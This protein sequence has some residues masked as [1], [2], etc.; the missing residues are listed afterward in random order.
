MVWKTW[1][2]GALNQGVTSLYGV[3]G[4]PPTR[5]LVHWGS[6]ATT[7]DYP[8]VALYELAAVGYAY[9]IA[10]PS[11]ENTRWLNVAVKAPGVFAEL[12]LTWLLYLAARRRYGVMAARW[13]STAYWSNPATILNGAVLGYI[14]P[15]MALP[16]VASVVAAVSGTP[17]LA[18][19]L[20]A[21]ACLTKAQAVFLFPVVVLAA[22]NGSPSGSASAVVRTLA[23]SAGAVAA[24]LSPYLVVGAGRN[25]V[26]GVASLLRHDMLSAYAA[27]IW[28]VVTYFLRASY[29][30]ADMG[31]WAAWTMPMRILG[32]STIVK[33]GYPDPRPFATT[34]L[35]AAAC[36]ALW[37]GRHARDLA[38]ACALGA[39][40]VHA[41]FVLG[42]AVHEN[43]LY[44]AVPLL[45]FAGCVRPR[46]RRVHFAVSAVIALNLFLFFGFG[47]ALP[48]PPRTFT[49]IDATVLLALANCLL[50]TWHARNFS[51]ECRAALDTRTHYRL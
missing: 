50:F 39:F 22:W 13:A 6:R 17:V 31:V 7:V 5:G 16:A 29:A 19:V 28:W 9:R 48:L 42:V 25:V 36:W 26:Q 24:L 21:I 1:S 47:R 2:Y 51:R 40:I 49:I 27:N 20:L 8:P 35:V 43:H 33:L 32:I 11:F 30:V 3:G 44:L 37:R 41:Y 23:A 18:G 14:D 10:S 34:A 38:L 4:N 45:A 15:L 12:A 46:L